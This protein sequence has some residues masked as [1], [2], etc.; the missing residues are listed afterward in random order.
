M[1]GGGGK[2][3]APTAQF[4]DPVSGKAFWTSDLLNQAINEREQRQRDE[5]AAARQQAEAKALQDKA[6]ASAKF[7][8]SL[9]GGMD[10]GRNAARDYFKQ[11]GVDPTGYDS[12]IEQALQSI[13]MMVPEN[14]PNPTGYF[15]KNP[16]IDLFTN[17]QSG[18]QQRALTNLNRTFGGDNFDSKLLGD[19]LVDPT[20]SRLVDERFNP[21]FGQLDNAKKRGTLNDVGYS[22][23]LDRFNTDKGTAASSIRSAATSELTKDRSALKGIRNEGLT[24]ASNLRLGEADLFNPADYFSRAQGQ[25]EREKGNFF[26]DVG[27]ALVGT[28]FSNLTELLNA[29][30]AVQGGVNPSGVNPTGAASQGGSA[31]G[32][33][34]DAMLADLRKKRQLSNQG[35]F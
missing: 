29:G 30:G 5:Q 35:A 21:L 1:C 32:T 25:A 31:I 6:D 14:D 16:G 9:T 27:N 28:E 15:A 24:S 8:Q 23:A 20:V 12:D 11:Q 4:V 18:A 26:S 7:Q 2:G 34:D 3:P 17:A 19:D 22:A 13:K 33:Y 10:Y